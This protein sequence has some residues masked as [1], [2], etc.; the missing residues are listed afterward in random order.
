MKNSY[1]IFFSLFLIQIYSTAFAGTGTG[2][3][4]SSFDEQ[5]KKANTSLYRD[6]KISKT[7]KEATFELLLKIKQDGYNADSIR[8]C[9]TDQE[10]RE[11]G[12]ELI[13]ENGQDYFNTPNYS[14]ARNFNHHGN[15]I[16]SAFNLCQISNSMGEVSMAGQ[17]L[18]IVGEKSNKKFI[19]SSYLGRASKCR[20]D[21]KCWKKYVE[22]RL[23]F[24]SKFLEV[25]KE[26][27]F[28]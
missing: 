1:F 27:F 7:D 24:I 26:E 22:K 2:T 17:C 8:V 21:S 11:D 15:N 28:Q 19:Y 10:C 9:L 20:P 12:W 6:I 14:E 3:G 25:S 23:L 13:S 4:T 18:T 16:S 5:I